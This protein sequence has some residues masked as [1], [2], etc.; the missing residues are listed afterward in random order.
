MLL[1]VSDVTKVTFQ[2]G[3]NP[4]LQ[5]IQAAKREILPQMSPKIYRDEE[6]SIPE[7]I[8]NCIHCLKHS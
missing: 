5:V 4:G 1:D 7:V 2:R 6:Y 3:K 8:L